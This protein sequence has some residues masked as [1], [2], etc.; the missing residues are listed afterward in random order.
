MESSQRVLDALQDLRS[1][2]PGKNSNRTAIAYVSMH[3]LFDGEALYLVPPGGSALDT[4]TWIEFDEF[5]NAFNVAFPDDDYDHKLLVLDCSRMP[6]NWYI[7]LPTND[8]SGAL[9]KWW[10]EQ[11]K[12]RFPFVTVLNSTDAGERAWASADLGG[13]VFGHFFRRGLAGEACRDGAWMGF[14]PP[15]VN[16][17]ELHAYIDEK[18]SQ[19]VEQQRGAAQHPILLSVDQDFEVA[20]AFRGRQS[21]MEQSA[22]LVRSPDTVSTSDRDSLWTSLEQIR[23]ARPYCSEPTAWR[24]LE[25]K[26]LWLEQLAA[27]GEAY[28]DLARQTRDELRMRFREINARSEPVGRAPT[29]HSCSAIIT[30]D[31]LQVP[32]NLPARSLALGEYL[33][34]FAPQTAAA[35]ADMLAEFAAA[36]NA[37]SLQA[38]LE[39]LTS[40]GVASTV[41]YQFLHMLQ[42]YQ[43]PRL[44]QQTARVQEL[45][46][47]RNLAGRLAVPGGTAGGDE[48][49]HDWVRGLLSSADEIRRAA[50]DRFFVD[51]D[52]LPDDHFSDA[53]FAY[54]QAATAARGV[55]RGDQAARSGLV[56]GSLLGR[57]ADESSQRASGEYPGCAVGIG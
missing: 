36:P 14:R 30:G 47:L 31:D 10:G 55:I 53:S 48:R 34:T 40:L 7:G 33:G 2:D 17:K 26:L 52:L 57:M 42:R 56:R 51:G 54:R 9:V 15:V 19:W 11:G 50:E 5:V 4:S 16:V 6:A 35:S 8:F 24:D 37:P 27:S 23:L 25:H 39:R 38:T 3:G 45:L 1:E 28:A 32:E 43:F 12:T 44:W 29:V 46:Q 22:K 20:S 21:L 49:T 41:D 18:V 13:S